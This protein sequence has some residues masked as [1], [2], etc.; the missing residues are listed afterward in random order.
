MRLDSFSNTNKAEAATT[1]LLS[2][3]QNSFN[4][5]KDLT[6]SLVN[7]LIGV[8]NSSSEFYW[9][10]NDSFSYSS[11]PQKFPVELRRVSSISS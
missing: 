6:I 10:S 8:K 9:K 3:I 5:F 7:S 1:S 2:S 11:Q 4:N